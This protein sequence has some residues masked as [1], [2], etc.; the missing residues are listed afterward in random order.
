MKW[1]IK[2]KTGDYETLDKGEKIPPVKNSASVICG[3]DNSPVEYPLF[4]SAQYFLEELGSFKY[5]HLR[6]S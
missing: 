6:K 4:D 2:F 1:Q 5:F 3:H